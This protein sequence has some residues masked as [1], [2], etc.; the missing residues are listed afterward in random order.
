MNKIAI[1]VGHAPESKGA[2]SKWLSPEFD[3]NKKVADELKKL[4]PEL[5]TIYTHDSYSGGYYKMQQSAA[6]KINKENFD[7][8]MELHYNSSLSPKS[9]GT[10]ACYWFASKK[11][12]E[13]AHII[14][15]EISKAFQT[16]NRG[17]RALANKND[18]GYWF[19][20]LMKAPAIIV[21]PFFGTNEFDSYKFQ[22][23]VKYATVLNSILKSII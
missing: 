11:G 6:D 8:V 23:Y 14:T 16:K 17:I 18:R 19:T 1:I 5:Y 12:K 4:N 9:N 7:L 21:E 22:D 13:Y 20:Y 10:E 3:Y 15:E 2:C